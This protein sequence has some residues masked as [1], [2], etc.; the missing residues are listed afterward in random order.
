MDM[1]RFD[2][3][4]AVGYQRVLSSI[5]DILS[6]IRDKARGDRRKDG[7]ELLYPALIAYVPSAFLLEPHLIRIPRLF[8]LTNRKTT[9]I[10][11]STTTDLA[12]LLT[13]CL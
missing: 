6:E 5:L 1:A 3:P 7:G 12:Q 9:Y 13:S 8:T 4:D 2:N 11:P 10:P